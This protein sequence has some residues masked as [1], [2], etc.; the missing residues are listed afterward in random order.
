MSYHDRHIRLDQSAQGGG[1]STVGIASDD[2]TK[3]SI[4]WGNANGAHPIVTV[5][6]GFLSIT[7]DE[8]IVGKPKL[9]ALRHAYTQRA[10]YGK[11]TRIDASILETTTPEDRRDAVIAAIDAGRP[12]VS[13]Q[14]SP[15]ALF[16]VVV[17]DVVGKL[18]KEMTSD[19][20][21]KLLGT[22]LQE[23]QNAAEEGCQRGRDETKRE[24]RDWLGIS[25]GPGGWN[26]WNP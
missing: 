12:D 19:R 1:F 9:Q 7:V 23:V 24:L 13:A 10:Y 21:I 4:H 22:A 18:A 25:R 6:I 14:I 26:N 16:D 5:Q 2:T 3:R 17:L 15:E 8:D 20:L 11:E